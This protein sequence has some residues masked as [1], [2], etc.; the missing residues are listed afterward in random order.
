MSSKVSCW[1]LLRL[2]I[3]LA[4]FLVQSGEGATYR[5]FAR[6]HID[7][8]KTNAPNPNA[9]CNRMMQRRG[10]TRGRC[11]AFNTF[12]NAPPRNIQHICRGG[13]NRVNP[14]Q[15]LYDSR[16]SFPLVNC[17][18]I[19]RYPNCRYTGMQANRR[20][21]VACVRRLPVH[22]ERVL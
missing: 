8:P 22:L 20:V 16:R 3:L 6:Q 19:G 17:R 7:H 11:K 5:D 13:G 10:M 2:A 9:Y 18:N 21:R 15:N 4:A 14:R 12:I 1:L